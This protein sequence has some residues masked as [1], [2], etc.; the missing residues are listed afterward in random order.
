MLRNSHS[1]SSCGP[2]LHVCICW[3]P[4]SRYQGTRKWSRFQPMGKGRKCLK[5]WVNALPH[6][7][8]ARQS[9]VLEMV[10]LIQQSIESWRVEK[11]EPQRPI[12][13]RSFY[14]LRR[15]SRIKEVSPVHDASS[16]EV[17]AEASEPFSDEPLGLIDGEG[18]AAISLVYS[19]RGEVA[20]EKADL[21]VPRP[22]LDGGCASQ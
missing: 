12:R 10:D 19:V 18:V 9:I 15:F 5:C 2:F 4:V 14:W 17:F 16:D 6:R 22:E 13:E 11:G 3:R 1:E 7:H 21:L 20:P 8:R